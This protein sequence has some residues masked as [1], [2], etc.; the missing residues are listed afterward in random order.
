ML[1][2][3]KKNRILAARYKKFDKMDTAALQA[4]LR[5]DLEAPADEQ[6]DMELIMYIAQ[7]LAERR[8]SASELPYRDLAAAK[9][10]FYA[11]YLPLLD[12][13]QALYDFA[14]DW[15]D[16]AEAPVVVE[17][18]ADAP[19]KRFCLFAVKPWRKLAGMAAVLVLLVF[20][21]TVT[22]N[23]LGF[24]PFASAPKWDDD[25]FWFECIM[26]DTG[27]PEHLPDKVEMAQFV[28]SWLPEGFVFD[29]ME[30]SKTYSTL[31]TILLYTRETPE[32][33]EIMHVSCFYMTVDIAVHYEKDDTEIVVYTVNDI[34][35]YIMSNLEHETVAWRNGNSECCFSGN[36]TVEEAK[37]IID[38]IYE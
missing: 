33:T 10:E 23:A 15:D 16:A 19:S 36:F 29:H 18:E 3:E 24:N 32:G 37:K 22:A 7:L 13:E 34:D 14:A 9:A 11:D 20:A 6:A 8:K 35:H 12:E 1:R 25:V 17:P 21:C 2:V 27:Q 31:D 30:T 26:E 28:P 4:F 5:A 38:S